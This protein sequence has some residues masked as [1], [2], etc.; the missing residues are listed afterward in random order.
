MTEQSNYPAPSSGWEV[1]S[2]TETTTVDAGGQIVQGVNVTYRTGNGVVG[3]VFVPLGAFT[4]DG[5]RAAIM[6]EAG[7][8]DAV[9]N[10]THPPAA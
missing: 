10:L 4:P 6:R 1:V 2:Q 5:V 3:T 8:R 7:I 9:S